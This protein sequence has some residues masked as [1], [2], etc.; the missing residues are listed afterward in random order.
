M[1]QNEG[2]TYFQLSRFG[3]SLKVTFSTSGSKSAFF[4]PQVEE[5]RMQDGKIVHYVAR[6]KK[7]YFASV[8]KF[9]F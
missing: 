4:E 2:N 8:K 6:E 5:N 3:K 1:R 9:T 7:V